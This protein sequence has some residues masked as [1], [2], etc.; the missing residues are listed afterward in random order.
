M[1]LRGDGTDSGS[2]AGVFGVTILKVRIP[3]PRLRCWS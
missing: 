2:N 1:W 3:V